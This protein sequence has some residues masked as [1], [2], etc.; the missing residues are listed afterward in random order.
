[1]ARGHGFL[2]RVWSKS[3]PALLGTGLLAAAR[4]IMNPP[5]S[6]SRVGSEFDAFLFAPI[7]EDRNG[8]PLSIVSL[9]GRMD[10]DPWQEAAHLAGLPAEAASQ[11]LATLLAALSDPSLKQVDAGKAATR[12]IAQLPGR[13]APDVRL[14]GPLRVRNIV[15]PH[16][17]VI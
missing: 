15:R 8:L 13:P 9:L 11:K 3:L 10:L 6:S 12:L 2:T 1:M 7:G 4:R 16:V 5:A 14:L 17:L